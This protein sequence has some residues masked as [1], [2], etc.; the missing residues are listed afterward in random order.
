MLN[1]TYC[2]AECQYLKCEKDEDEDEMTACST[3]AVAA[4]KIFRRKFHESQQEVEALGRGRGN[5]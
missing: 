1:K 5:L 3:C 4:A 2:S